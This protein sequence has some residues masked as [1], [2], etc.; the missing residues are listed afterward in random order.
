MSITA[1]FI[2]SLEIPEYLALSGTSIQTVATAEND[3]LSL[4]AFT[5]SNDTAGAIVCKLYHND[6]SSEWLIWTG[7]VPANSSV[8]VTDNPVRLRNTE[9]IRASGNTNVT[10]K[11]SLIS[12]LAQRP[13]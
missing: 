10:V 9:R 4:A 3:T 11:L 6:N 13:S 5:F 12:Q 7:S 1:N 8:T 2:G